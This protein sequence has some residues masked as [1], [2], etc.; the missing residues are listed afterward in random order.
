MGADLAGQMG[1][2]R[3]ELPVKPLEELT[4]LGLRDRQIPGSDFGQP[5]EESLRLG[6]DLDP[7]ADD[8]AEALVGQQGGYA[9][10]VPVQDDHR[11][12]QVG[13]QPL[14]GQRPDLAADGQPCVDL[15]LGEPEFKRFVGL[16]GML[17]L[18][19]GLSLK[20]Y[21]NPKHALAA[22]A[23]A[24]WYYGNHLHLHVDWN[25]HIMLPRAADFDLPFYVGVGG[26]FVFWF[27][28]NHPHWWGSTASRLD[29]NAGLGVRVPIGIAF[30]LNKVPL[31]IF[32]EVVPGL[33]LIPNIGF[34]IDGAVGVRYYF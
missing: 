18:P 29:T 5:H 2:H 32:I 13:R 1:T 3:P 21:F 17:G 7:Q 33:G 25:Y 10:P 28:D 24:S 20:Y 12:F 6:P 16:G 8:R 15:I 31:D 11:L 26:L 14:A 30:N 34:F 19:T 22:G 4:D 27:H 23:G 9:Y